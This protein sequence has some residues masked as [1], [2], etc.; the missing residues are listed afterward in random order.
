MFLEIV[1][2]QKKIY[3]GQVR[4]VNV[5]GSQGAFGILIHHA[6]II[7]TLEEGRIKII[8]NDGEQHHFDINGG[9]VEAVNDKVIILAE[10]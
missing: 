10:M 1:T 3:E 7:S 6:P 8:E 9:I 4:L 2:P 5:P